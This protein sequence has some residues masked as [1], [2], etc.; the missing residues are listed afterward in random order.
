MNNVSSHTIGAVWYENSVTL[1]KD[2]AVKD[3]AIIHFASKAY[4]NLENFE[5]KRILC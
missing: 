1:Y 4:R 2:Y 5:H 3:T